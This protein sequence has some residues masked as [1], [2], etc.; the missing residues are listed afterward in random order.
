M[1]YEK[2]NSNCYT[3]TKFASF[4]HMSINICNLAYFTICTGTTTRLNSSDTDTAC[5]KCFLAKNKY[6]FSNNTENN[7]DTIAQI[8]KINLSEGK[9]GHNL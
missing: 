4:A 5:E 1:V 8:L 3:Y 6:S 9:N 7:D 2:K